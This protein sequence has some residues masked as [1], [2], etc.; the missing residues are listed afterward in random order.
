[1]WHLRTG[2]SKLPV[3]GRRCVHTGFLH[4]NLS[5]LDA[6]WRPVSFMTVTPRAAVSGHVCRPD[7][8][9]GLDKQLDS[10]LCL[11]LWPQPLCSSWHSIYLQVITTLSEPSPLWK[12]Q[13][14]L[15]RWE[16]AQGRPSALA[17]RL[18][19]FLPQWLGLDGNFSR[20]ASVLGNK[21]KLH[22]CHLCNSLWS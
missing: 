3:C 18:S 7:W 20:V 8:A 16:W 5:N 11:D 21:N 1:M 14:S 10:S 15:C 22:Q 19:S 6:N 9:L 12:W 13:C 4:R 2:V 17:S